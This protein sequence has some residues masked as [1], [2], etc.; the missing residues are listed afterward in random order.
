[1]EYIL[2][3]SLVLSTFTIAS[4]SGFGSS[5]LLLTLG[6]NFF[7]LKF[8]LPVS[9]PLNIALNLLIIIKNYKF[10]SKRII[11]TIIIPYFPAGFIAGVIVFHTIPVEK[12][13]MVIFGLFIVLTTIRNMRN[14]IFVYD[15]TDSNI[16]KGFIFAAGTMHGLFA[17]GGPLLVYAINRLN[18]NKNE[19][20]S[21]LPVV[22]STMNTILIITYIHSGIMTQDKLIYSLTLLP[23]AIAGFFAGEILH[24]RIDEKMFKKFVGVLLIISGIS[25]IIKNSGITEFLKS[26]F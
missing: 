14:K 5:L 18:L 4:V 23:F 3:S 22:W 19:F 9:L 11:A 24:A 12:F 17:T 26:F 15:N 16:I 25:I 20:R 8:L 2:L 7:S 13:L 1:M 6:L 21:T 10:V